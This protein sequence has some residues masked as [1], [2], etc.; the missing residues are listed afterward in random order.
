MRFQPKYAFVNVT[1]H[2]KRNLSGT[3]IGEELLCV[4][5]TSIIRLHRSAQELPFLKKFKKKLGLA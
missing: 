1:P 2:L 5:C 3:L 4:L